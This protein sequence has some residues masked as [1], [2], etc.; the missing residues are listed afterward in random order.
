MSSVEL[1]STL[2]HFLRL[3]NSS[4]AAASFSYPPTYPSSLSQLRDGIYL[5]RLLHTL[6]PAHFDLEGL[7]TSTPHTPPSSSSSSSSSSL[8][9]SLHDVDV[10]QHLLV[11]LETTMEDVLGLGRGVDLSGVVDVE[12]MDDGD[13]LRLVQVA[14]LCCINSTR[15]EEVVERVMDMGEKEQEQMMAAVHDIM[16][17]LHLPQADTSTATPARR[18][19]G[20]SDG[21]Q[22]GPRSPSSQL[23]TSFVLPSPSSA[24]TPKGGLSAAVVGD[25]RVVGLER[26]LREL[27]RLNAELLE[28]MRTLKLD[29]ERERGKGAEEGLQRAEKEWSERWAREQQKHSRELAEVQH[30]VAEL[31]SSLQAQQRAQLALEKEK[32]SLLASVDELRQRAQQLDD[33]L[34]VA[35]AKALQAGQLEAKVARLTGMLSSVGDIKAQAEYSEEEARKSVERI[36]QLEKEVKEAAQLKASVGRL[37]ALVVKKEEEGLEWKLK[38][39]ELKAEVD[40]GK[41]T[42][43]ERE[44]QAREAEDEARRLQAQLAE[45]ESR[46]RESGEDA[47]HAGGGFEVIGTPTSSMREK[48][49][50][51]EAEVEGLRGRRSGS[52]SSAVSPRSSSSSS[53][54]SSAG[55]YTEAE[56]EV[57]RS[58]ATAHE[59]R[60]IDAMRKVQQLERQLRQ[61]QQPLTTPQQQNEEMER[62]HKQLDEANVHL[63]QLSLPSISTSSSSSST[64]AC[65]SSN[66]SKLRKYAELWRVA[67][68]KVG[69]YRLA[70]EGWKK[71]EASMHEQLQQLREAI[72]DRENEVDVRERV[73]VEEMAVSLRERRIMQAAFHNLGQEWANSLVLNRAKGGAAAD[74]QRQSGARAWLAQQRNK[75]LD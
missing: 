75:T 17:K 13:V 63:L 70:E 47:A 4:L 48:I 1:S 18:S 9:A 61:T 26:E 46:E 41:E 8:D 16:A 52:S 12:R 40:E 22:A 14:V 21:S 66:A 73:R 59:T 72:R 15:K 43:K 62:L 58:I 69:E 3:F 57:V 24:S 32:V 27:K 38:V 25:A 29:G 36:H 65:E 31:S 71:V 19:D 45:R 7:S 23:N 35:Q 54:S 53:S 11:S 74:A 30:R 42:L 67:H 56:M 51:L 64:P 2:L 44:R 28:E 68:R 20:S 10:L 5:Y 60:Y 34:Q 6:D 39:E 50:R 49:R 37:K 33:E 55:M